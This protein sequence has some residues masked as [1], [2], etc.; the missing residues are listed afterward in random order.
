MI[1]MIDQL[2]QAIP[3]ASSKDIDKFVSP[4]SSV[5]TTYKIDTPKRIA[6]FIAQ[7]AHESQNM[8]KLVE[9]LNYSAPRL[10]A[11]FPKRFK[12]IE[13]ANKYAN[14]PV[15]LGNYV[16]ANRYGNGD[17]ASGDGYKYRARGL[18]HHTFKDNY[19][20]LTKDLK[21]DYVSNPNDLFLPFHAS[22]G[23]AWFWSKR[24]CNELA[25]DSD[26]KAITIKINGGLNG[27]DD[28]QFHWANA[29]ETFG[30]IL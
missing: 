28:R 9:N 29:R 16:Y 2:K 19:K 8:S 27:Y 23:A 22:L 11:V 10:M 24:G 17:E 6:A 20:E 26:F 4:L 12:T 15:A 21:N 7:I 25:D 13:F 18:M 3:R 14:N 30:V 5:M 1:I